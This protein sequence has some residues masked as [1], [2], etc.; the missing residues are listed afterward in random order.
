[1]SKT[2][3][4]EFHCRSPATTE[5]SPGSCLVAFCPASR[6][7]RCLRMPSRVFRTICQ[8]HVHARLP[9][10]TSVDEKV[11]TRP[12]LTLGVDLVQTGSIAVLILVF[13]QWTASVRSACPV[14]H[15]GPR[16]KFRCAAITMAVPRLRGA[17]T[18]LELMLHAGGKCDPARSTLAL[19]DA[20]RAKE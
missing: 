2:S 14:L 13:E 20:W 5:N 10:A 12:F 4:M 16:S 17:A 7:S 1:M 8:E 9:I 3:V 6:H 11:S 15:G 18:C 19:L